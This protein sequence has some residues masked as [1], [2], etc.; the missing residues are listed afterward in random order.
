MRGTP[1]LT[2]PISQTGIDVLV[3]VLLF[4]VASAAEAPA[5]AAVSH[6]EGIIFDG[7]APASVARG[8]CRVD[9]ARLGGRVAGISPAGRVRR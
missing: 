2:R 5:V 7:S 9:H 8:Q 6:C 1:T 4:E 3:E